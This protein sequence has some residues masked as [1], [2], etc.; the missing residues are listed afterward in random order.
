MRESEGDDW[1]AYGDQIIPAHH[2][3]INLEII[4]MD[5]SNNI[6]HKN[7]SRLIIYLSNVQAYE[8][9]QPTSWSDYYRDSTQ[10]FHLFDYTIA[11]HCCTQQSYNQKDTKQ[12]SKCFQL[13]D[14]PRFRDRALMYEEIV[15]G[16]DKRQT[17]QQQQGCLHVERETDVCDQMKDGEPLFTVDEPRCITTVMDNPS[18]IKNWARQMK[19]MN[20]WTGQFP[21]KIS[22]LCNVKNVSKEPTLV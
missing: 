15:L 17:T 10:V 5:N 8:T 2:F 14:F 19:L 16:K 3:Q 20:R 21:Q 7:T 11:S 6:F 4:G 1:Q 18:F 22:L 13:F 12:S 9:V